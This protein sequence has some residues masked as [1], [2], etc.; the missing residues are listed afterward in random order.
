[1]TVFFAL[2]GYLITRL[3]LDERDASKTISLRRFYR[4]RVVRL[5]PALLVLVALLALIWPILHPPAE[6]ADVA[7]AVLLQYSNWVAAYRGFAALDPLGPCWSLAVEWQFYLI[8]PLIVALLW[9]VLRLRAGA[10]AVLLVAAGILAVL[11]HDLTVVD[12]PLS[13]YPSSFVHADTLTFG[14]AAAFSER[15]RLERGRIPRF[16]GRTAGVL[17]WGMF[18]ILL[19]L[20]NVCE[21]HQNV[22]LK[23]WGY[24]PVSIFAA[25]I[26]AHLAES[27]RGS[28]ARVMAWKPLVALGK[29]AYG[30]YLYQL[31]VLFLLLPAR[32][33]HGSQSIELSTLL[34]VGA[35]VG[36]AWLSYWLVET[37][38]RRWLRGQ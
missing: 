11:R 32:A 31:P 35:S 14:A 37:P 10:V 15:V 6:I 18:G 38:C 30:L 20:F 23:L 28:L 1:M 3:L 19:V 17:A 9:K 2:S 13:Y 29:R 22:W 21:L 34:Y 5:Y 7:P 33:P 4:H 8:W 36:M 24:T 16:A 25:S 26:V 27:P 12:S